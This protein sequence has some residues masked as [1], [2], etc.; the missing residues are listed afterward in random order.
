MA[1]YYST[2]ESEEELI[3]KIEKIAILNEDEDGFNILGIKEI[4]NTNVIK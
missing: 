2:I 1:G 4:A 3:N